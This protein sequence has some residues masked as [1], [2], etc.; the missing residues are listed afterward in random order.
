MTFL[1][2]EWIELSIYLVLI[3]FS[4]NWTIGSSLQYIWFLS[5]FLCCFISSILNANPV[6][7]SIIPPRNYVTLMSSC[8]GAD[9]ME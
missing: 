9:Y 2:K 4:T 8:N 3:E 7:A 1:S 5:S 6:T